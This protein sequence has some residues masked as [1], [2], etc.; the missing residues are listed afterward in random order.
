MDGH[1]GEA[2]L[3]IFLSRLSELGVEGVDLRAAELLQLHAADVRRDVALDVLHVGVVGTGPDR[4]LHRRQPLLGQ[5]LL[6]RSLARGGVV[7]L[8]DGDEQLVHRRLAL[9]ARGEAALGLAAALFGLMQ[10]PAAPRALLLRP[11]LDPQPPAA[12]LTSLRRRHADVD[13]V[14]PAA[15]LAAF[16]YVTSHVPP[17]D[18]RLLCNSSFARGC[19]ASNERRR[20]ESTECLPTSNLFG[21]LQVGTSSARWPRAGGSGSPQERVTYVR[22]AR[23]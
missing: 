17:P 16:P 6:D 9:L 20:T 14:L 11:S 4:G 21:A 15:G 8:L 18:A 7:V 1:G 22:A 23:I 13:D 3:A 5:V 19:A 12:D 10:G 2:L